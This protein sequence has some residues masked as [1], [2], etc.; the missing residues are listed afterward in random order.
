MSVGLEGR[1]LRLSLLGPFSLTDFEGRSFAPKAQKERA[2]LALLA[3]APQGERSRAWLRDK[4]WSDRGEE[5]AGASLRQALVRLRKGLARWG[6]DL[7][8]TDRHTV[9]LDLSKIV[10]DTRLLEEGGVGTAGNRPSS[11]LGPPPEFLEGL[12]VADPEFE[13]WL[14]AERRRWAVFLEE[15]AR[16]TTP[17]RAPV[18]LA[19]ASGPTDV[20]AAGNQDVERGALTSRLG[21]GLLPSI[22]HG[23]MPQITCLADVVAESLARS[24]EELLS[25]D[26][27]DFR[28][29][30]RPLPE[31]EGRSGAD[32]LIRVRLL[33]VGPDVTL[34]L[35]VYRASVTR[36]QWSQ[37]IQTGLEE[38]L[39][40][41]SLTLS[42]F[43]NQNVDRLASMIVSSSSTSSPLDDQG[44]LAKT[45]YLALNSMY[46]LS[47][48]ATL[49]T[50]RLLT[51]AARERPDS[52]FGALL[53]YNNSFRIGEY[54]GIFDEEHR[55]QALAFADDAEA[56]APFNS[57]TLACLG[58][59]RGFVLGDHERAGEL[60]AHAVEI[61]PL[62]AFAWDH[63]AL[64][65]IYVGDYAEAVRAAGRAVHL[66]SYNPLR[67][68]F[69]TTLCMGAT[70]AGDFRTA[71]HFGQRA[72]SRQPRFA[73][74]MR[75]LVASYH[76]AG[77]HEDARSTL[78][79]LTAISSDFSQASLTH[80]GRGL[81]DKDARARLL[82]AFVAS[83]LKKG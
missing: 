60:L 75:Y 41:G 52:L 58:H 6:Q 83:G 71:I 50:D 4:L 16:D 78:R 44:C 51:A 76:D 47:E 24:V 80:Y 22:V 66:G 43:I 35:F 14:R 61:N 57:I 7:I 67:Y 77:R 53:A 11:L 39:A 82:S 25:L 5:Q 31:F 15:R 28:E 40:D 48:H 81:V 45:T 3:L 18:A 37:S 79:R 74:A 9:G 33:Q 13:D 68:T 8:R 46:R 27:Y 36:L 55:R 30:G 17:T 62:Q 63:Y 34:T 69:E 59:V 70:L 19:A 21:L 32:Y 26:I 64:H 54:L 2:L 12:D 38:M 1:Q 10:V 42:G 73:A 56:M 65:K 23:T 29:A 72:L 20:A 49:E